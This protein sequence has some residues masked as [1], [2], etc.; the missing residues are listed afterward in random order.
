[1]SYL[2]DLIKNLQQLETMGLDLTPGH[3]RNYQNNIVSTLSNQYMNNIVPS[4]KANHVGVELECYS[5]FTRLQFVG[6]LTKYNLGKKVCIA[7]D[8]SIVPPPPSIE[9][10][11]VG[12]SQKYFGYEFKIIDT[13]DDIFET[14]KVFETVLKEGL[15]EVNSTCGLHV[16]LDMRNRKYDEAGD[17]LIKCQNLFKKLVDANRIGNHFCPETTSITDPNRGAINLTAVSRHNT[18]EVRLHHATTDVSLIQN[19]IKLLLCIVN[20]DTKF[21]KKVSSVK[22]LKNSIGLLPKGLQK[23]I[24]TQTKKVGG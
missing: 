24:T 19:W 5:P 7:S 11:I 14:L 8:S 12:K 4:S 20:V 10:V 18:I 17:R 13:E 3:A 16:H 2:S 21:E 23:Y 22:E 9:D 6:L 15:V 1:M